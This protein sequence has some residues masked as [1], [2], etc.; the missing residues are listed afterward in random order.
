MLFY[1]LWGFLP[2]QGLG[3]EGDDI[4]DSKR[5]VTTF[6]LFQR[7]PLEFRR[8]FDH[9]RSLP[10]DGRPNYD[11]FCQLFDNLLVEEGSQSDVAFDWDDAG[12]KH[13]GRVFKVTGDISPHER[14]PSFKR[15]MG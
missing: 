14:S 9:C 7:L 15:N 11:H 8:F 13:R 10:F 1:F 4:V 12:A 2:W 6:T 3:L 5:G